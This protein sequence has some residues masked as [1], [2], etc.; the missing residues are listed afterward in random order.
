MPAGGSNN[1]VRYRLI[2]VQLKPEAIVELTQGNLDLFRKHYRLPVDIVLDDPIT[3]PFCPSTQTSDRPLWVR[4]AV[5]IWDRQN[6][7][8]ANCALFWI[9]DIVAV[10]GDEGMEPFRTVANWI[11]GD[12]VSGGDNR[13]RIAGT[14]YPGLRVVCTKE[15]DMA[16][17]PVG[18]AI[19]TI[20][21]CQLGTVFIDVRPIKANNR[22]GLQEDVVQG[23]IA[24]AQCG[25]ELGQSALRRH[26]EQNQLHVSGV[27]CATRHQDTRVSVGDVSGPA[28]HSRRVVGCR[29]RMI[30]LVFLP[31]CTA[32]CFGG[33]EVHGL[34]LVVS[35][36]DHGTVWR[37]CQEVVDGIQVN[38]HRLGENRLN[39]LVR[40]ASGD[41]EGNATNERTEVG[42]VGRVLV[43]VAVKNIYRD[44]TVIVVAG[45]GIQNARV[46]I[47]F[48][49]VRDGLVGDH[50][51]D[52]NREV[53]EIT[54]RQT[55]D[56]HALCV[57]IVAV[58]TQCNVAATDAGFLVLRVAG[59]VD[60][61]PGSCLPCSVIA[62]VEGAEGLTRSTN[63]VRHEIAW[64]VSD[65]YRSF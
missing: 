49:L 37:H 28:Y 48:V 62:Y 11:V 64:V 10:W 23:R 18:L 54:T 59:L 5:V 38:L 34:E 4:D 22:S 44:T 55:P 14:G 60:E 35:D 16:N 26:F 19:V 3:V 29:R 33:V 12:H 45:N 65:L 51:V 61:S 8:C 20:H 15:L 56:C 43:H 17:T 7:P 31:R 58:N 40:I 6:I 24:V 36:H 63:K 42:S 30:D 32:V 27:G 9:V 25:P 53:V 41:V 21:H 13:D 47:L 57:A 39:V 2:R 52:E 1:R 50:Q 46:F